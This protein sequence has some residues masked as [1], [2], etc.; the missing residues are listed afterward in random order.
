MKAR[1]AV[2]IPCF[3]VS[4]SIADVVN[5]IGDEVIRIYCVNDACPGETG[6]ILDRLATTDARVTVVH[7]TVNTGVGGATK[8]GYQAAIDDGMDVIVKLDGDG[9]MDPAIIPDLI[10]P[11]LQG[12][13]DYVKGNRFFNMASIKQIPRSR[14]LGNIALSFLTKLS[15]GYWDLFDPVNGFTAIHAAVANELELNKLNDRYFFES[16]ILFRMAIVRGKVVEIPMVSV[17]AEE[18][19]NMSEFKVL[20]TF[21]FLHARNFLKRLM[22]NYF[23]RGFS[24]ASISIISGTCLTTFGLVVGVTAWGQ[25]IET[26]VTATTGTVMLAALPFLVGIQMLFNFLNFDIS[27][28]PSRP[29]HKDLRKL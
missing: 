17:Y 5:R 16:D 11:I 1:V 10:A 26:G 25:S 23:L 22:Y 24:I 2:V 3:K 21:P 28:L 29:I 9:Q 12:E 7:H 20:M 18:A 13:A 15:T 4:D 6:P 27:N 14:M 8:T 19:S